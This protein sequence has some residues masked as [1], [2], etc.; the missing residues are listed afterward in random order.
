MVNGQNS[1]VQLLLSNNAQVRTTDINGKTVLH[2][3]AACGHLV[4]MQ[5]IMSY[6][7]E[8]EIQAKDK[9]ECTALHWACYNGKSF[10][11]NMLVIKCLTNFIH[12]N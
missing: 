3:A 7:T 2:L 6:M 9:Q 5:M 11:H 1:I 10:N 4:C 12:L 8:E